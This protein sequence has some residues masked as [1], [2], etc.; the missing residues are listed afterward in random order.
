MRV[1]IV[2]GSWFE[3][4]PSE[5]RG[6]IDLVVAN[7]PY[8][9]NDELLPSSVID[10]E[11][12]G[13]LFAGEGGLAAI[14]EIVA[15]APDWLAPHGVLVVEI[16]A[17][18]GPDAAAT[19]RASGFDEVEVRPDLAGRDRVLVARRSPTGR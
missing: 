18:Q 3:P 5:L 2:E 4:L 7:P 10:W 6:R 8:V 14:R 19:A 11:P 16:G 12:I 15:A 13:A 9:R 1:T 17:D